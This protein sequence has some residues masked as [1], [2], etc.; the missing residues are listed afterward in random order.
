MEYLRVFGTQK[1]AF[2]IVATLKCGCKSYNFTEINIKD[3][4][5]PFS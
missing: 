3:Y 5:K 4:Y 1:L 2:F